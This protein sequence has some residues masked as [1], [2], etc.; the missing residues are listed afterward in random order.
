MPRMHCGKKPWIHNFFL[1]KRFWPTK[2]NHRSQMKNYL[3]RRKTHALVILPTVNIVLRHFQ[4]VTLLFARTRLLL[5]RGLCM[6]LLTRNCFL[7][8]GLFLLSS[9]SL[10]QRT[11]FCFCTRPHQSG[12][13]FFLSRKLGRSS[14]S[15]QSCLPA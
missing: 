8:R 14:R 7:R 3:S 9:R 12:A 4:S 11:S 5:G 13:T 1:V 15:L 10:G 2:T 6:C